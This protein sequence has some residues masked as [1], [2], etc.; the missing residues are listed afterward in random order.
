MRKKTKKAKK[1]MMS[2]LMGTVMM[3]KL[4]ESEGIIV[5]ASQ[6]DAF[7]VEE[8]VIGGTEIEERS[9]AGQQE[10]KAPSGAM[11]ERSNAGQQGSKTPSGAMTENGNAGQQEKTEISETP[12]ETNQEAGQKTNQGTDRE[13]NQV[14]EVKRE[15]QTEKESGQQSG[16][17]ENEERGNVQPKIQQKEGMEENGAGETVFQFPQ[18]K[19]MASTESTDRMNGTNKKAEIDK[20]KQEKDEIATQQQKDEIATQRQKDEIATQQQDQWMEIAGICVAVLLFLV[21]C[22]RIWRTRFLTI[23]E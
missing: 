22:V 10:S 20:V 14:T 5:L 8:A 17:Q 3:S 15:K 19:A 13:T 2:L 18:K 12:Q 21:G 11:T 7:I 23:S 6:E 1:L 4:A 16:A 9:N